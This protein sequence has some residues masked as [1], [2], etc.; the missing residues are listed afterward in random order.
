[1]NEHIASVFK[2]VRKSTGMTQDALAEELGYSA[3][4]IGMLEQGN[5]RPSYKL[6][7]MIIDKYNIDA[8]H[9]FGSTQNAEKPID[10]RA[11]EAIQ[12][13]LNEVREWVWTYAKSA[14]KADPEDPDS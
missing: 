3:G 11:I 5:A 7:N 9:F 2:Y 13:H 14:S 10:T 1:M 8:N 6:M 4:H 12:N